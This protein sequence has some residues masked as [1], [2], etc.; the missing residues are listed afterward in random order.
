MQVTVH[1]AKTNLS[2]LID[3]AL[4]GEEVVIAKG[5]KPVVKL[6]PIER[7]SFKIGI[8]KGKLTGDAPDFLTDMDEEEL[9]L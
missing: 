4:S 9:A 1:A 8:L 3:A 5:S 2:K 7:R 6:V